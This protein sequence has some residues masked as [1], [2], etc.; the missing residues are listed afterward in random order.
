VDRIGAGL[1]IF[2]EKD[3]W[4]QNRFGHRSFHETSQPVLSTRTTAGRGT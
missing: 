2:N 1:I 4:G 3:F